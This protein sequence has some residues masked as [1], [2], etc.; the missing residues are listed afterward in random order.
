MNV[1]VFDKLFSHYFENNW[2]VSKIY[3]SL[4]GENDNTS[5]KE[6]IK[7]F[8]SQ[9]EN[10]FVFAKTISIDFATHIVN[11]S[12]KGPSEALN[13]L[14]DCKTKDLFNLTIKIAK[15]SDQQ[16]LSEIFDLDLNDFEKTL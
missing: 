8:L 2:N 1:K 6:T 12:M 9:K 10:F 11:Q 13:N 7:G 15:A 5:F 3:T 4:K 16:P 14:K